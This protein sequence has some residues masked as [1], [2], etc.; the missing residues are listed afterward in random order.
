MESRGGTA[1]SKVLSCLDVLWL[2]RPWEVF[3]RSSSLAVG[4][5]ADRSMAKVVYHLALIM[6]GKE[7]LRARSPAEVLGDRYVP[8]SQRLVD[9]PQIDKRCRREF[10]SS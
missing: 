6:K 1:S 5:I 2:D 3:G 7:A 8:D 4:R 9:E 10:E